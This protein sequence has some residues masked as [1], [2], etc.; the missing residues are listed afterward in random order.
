LTANFSDFT[1]HFI[2]RLMAKEVS[3]GVGEGRHWQIKKQPAAAAL[4][5]FKQAVANRL[6]RKISP[7]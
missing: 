3:Y 6:D 1:P 2:L 5:A 7:E 4:A